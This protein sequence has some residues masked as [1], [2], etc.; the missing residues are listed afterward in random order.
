MPVKKT[1]KYIGFSLVV[2]SVTTLLLTGIHSFRSYAD[3][4]YNVTKI[5]S[6]LT[7]DGADTVNENT[8]YSFTLTKDN[9]AEELV[10]GFVD[11][12][13]AQYVNFNTQELSLTPKIFPTH[14]GTKSAP[15][16][17]LYFLLLTATVKM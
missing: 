5:S 8:D 17:T 10:S 1:A 6:G 13:N 2:L 14:A 9:P 7:I 3:N 11:I 12:E 4:I 15:K 16:V